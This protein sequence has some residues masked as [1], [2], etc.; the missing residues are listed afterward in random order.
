[1]LIQKL[2]MRSSDKIKGTTFF[3]KKT[4][5]FFVK[6]LIFLVD[7]YAFKYNNKLQATRNPIFQQKQNRTL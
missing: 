6:L 3:Y 7:Y 2:L 1:M 4:Q 5:F